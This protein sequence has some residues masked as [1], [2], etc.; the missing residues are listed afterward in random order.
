MK[1]KLHHKTTMLLLGVALCLMQGYSVMAQRIDTRLKVN[2]YQSPW[3]EDV[4]VT[5]D[6]KIVLAGEIWYANGKEVSSIVR[7]NARGSVDASFKTNF[8]GYAE[9]VV[10]IKKGQYLVWDECGDVLQLSKTG[11]VIQ[12]VEDFSGWAEEVLVLADGSMIAYGDGEFYKYNSNFEYDGTWADGGLYLYGYEVNQMS[13]YGDKIYIAGDFY[14]FNGYCI[15]DMVRLNMDGSIDWDFSIGSGV[16]GDNNG[17]GSFSFLPD[18]RILLGNN[19]YNSVDNTY[20][21]GELPLLENDGYPTYFNDWDFGYITDVVVQ[22][23]RVVVGSSGEGAEVNAFNFEGQYDES[24]DGHYWDGAEDMHVTGL[25][26]DEV[27]VT[28]AWDGPES[29]GIDKL[30]KAG[31]KQK[32]FDPP[33]HD[34]GEIGDIVKS[35]NFYYV[36]GSFNRIDKTPAHTLA[37]VRSNGAAD[38]SFKLAAEYIPCINDL[39]PF[40]NQSVMVNSGCWGM[41]KFNANGSYAEFYW[42]YDGWDE[43]SV[44]PNGKI[45]VLTSGSLYSRNGDGTLDESFNNMSISSEGIDMDFQSDGKII[46]GGQYSINGNDVPPVV[47]LNTNGSIDETF[48]LGGVGPD[49]DAVTRVAVN[50]KNEVFVNGYFGYWNDVDLGFGDYYS[51]AVVLKKDGEADYDLSDALSGNQILVYYTWGPD[52]LGFRDGFILPT[53]SG[54]MFG[55][56]LGDLSYTSDILPGTL[57]DYSVDEFRTSSPEEL[58]LVGYTYDGRTYRSPVTRFIYA[59]FVEEEEVTVASAAR[60]MAAYPNPT[61]DYVTFDVKSAVKVSIYSA[62]GTLKVERIVKSSDEKIDV[63]FLHNGRYVVKISKDGKIATQHLIKD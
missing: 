51:G 16:W 3:F 56:S 32:S 6:K 31:V 30:S 2:A 28:N 59:P 7:I 25:A 5:A 41:M 36:Y 21:W 19:Y 23:S 14:N 34:D 45:L 1:T 54:S 49:V 10:E 61:K 46:L 13:V 53:T 22:S 38:R 55:T 60:S 8:D 52:P 17:V 20:Y 27:L 58:F 48:A 63:S 47:R 9:K 57:Q 24:Y 15:K 43:I 39:Y 62:D 12:E 11:R 26:G 4:T 29:N 37:R 40:P 50:A 35:G 18:G 33:V 42:P 44:R